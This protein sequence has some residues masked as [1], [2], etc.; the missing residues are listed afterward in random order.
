LIVYLCRQ[1]R[2]FFTPLF[3]LFFN[4]SFPH[5]KALALEKSR[6]KDPQKILL[7]LFKGK[8]I[9]RRFSNFIKIKKQVPFQL[10]KLAK[11]MI[12]KDAFKNLTK[13][14]NDQVPEIILNWGSGSPKARFFKNQEVT[15]FFSNLFYKIIDISKHNQLSIS[16]NT[17]DLFHGHLVYLNHKRGDLI[18]V[19]HAQEY[20][21]ELPFTRSKSI[22]AVVTYKSI[23]K[24][25]KFGYKTVSFKRRNFIWSLKE[26]KLFNLNTDDKGPFFSLIFPK[27]WIENKELKRLA[28]LGNSVQD[29]LLGN[30]LGSLN[31]FPD[32][33]IPLYWSP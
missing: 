2:K 26:N 12:T 19:F 30:G 15:D 1:K 8:P 9:H 18:I 13:N 21:H 20:P 11:G 25:K 27:G 33:K 16:L 6:L 10:Q 32:Q 23:L 7:E 24:G 28:L 4:F 29:N 31:F 17:T 3:I 14:Y 5:E 22:E